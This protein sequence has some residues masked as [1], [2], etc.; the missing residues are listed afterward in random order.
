MASSDWLSAHSR[1][2]PVTVTPWRFSTPP[3][4][5]ARW[6]VGRRRAEALSV[7]VLLLA[8]ALGW[9]VRGRRSAGVWGNRL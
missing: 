4:Q 9:F 5:R 2:P 3:A 8:V 7:G 1:G 6:E